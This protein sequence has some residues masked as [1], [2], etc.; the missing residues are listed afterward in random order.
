MDPCH[1]STDSVSLAAVRA[2]TCSPDR[3]QQ[4]EASTS[5]NTNRSRSMSDEPGSSLK[6]HALVREKALE[7][8]AINKSATEKQTSQPKKTSQASKKKK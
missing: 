4:A 3:G 2:K 5:S 6:I 7:N 1:S 8:V